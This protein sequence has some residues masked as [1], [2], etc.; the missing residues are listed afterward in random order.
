MYLKCNFLDNK[1]K[2]KKEVKENDSIL[3]ENHTKCI[4]LRPTRSFSAYQTICA[5]DLFP[6]QRNL[7]DVYTPHTCIPGLV[8]QKKLVHFHNLSSKSANADFPLYVLALHYTTGGTRP[9][10]FPLGEYGPFLVPRKSMKAHAI[11]SM[12]VVLAA[13]ESATEDRFQRRRPTRLTVS[14]T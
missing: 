6:W 4:G 3:V 8:W 14:R 13:A 12:L 10:F 5:S 11:L 2:N 9:P 7:E 1:L